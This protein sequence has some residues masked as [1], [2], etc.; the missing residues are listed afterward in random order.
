M[1]NLSLAQLGCR[2]DRL[3]REGPARGRSPLFGGATQYGSNASSAYPGQFNFWADVGPQTLLPVQGLACPCGVC[4]CLLRASLPD[5][6]GVHIPWNISTRLC[7]HMGCPG[8][9]LLTGAECPAGPVGHQRR[10]QAGGD[11]LQRCDPRAG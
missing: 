10:H 9:G 2:V 11:L 8:A 3:L 6:V 4:C 5:G 1:K 7:C